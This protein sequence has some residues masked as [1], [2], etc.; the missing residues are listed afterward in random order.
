[1]NVKLIE[2]QPVTVA[3]LRYI[4]PYGESIG[5]F[6]QN[7]YYP[8]ALA[9]NLLDHP[10]YGISHDDPSSTAP[11]TAGT[12]RSAPAAGM[13]RSPSTAMANRWVRRGRRGFA[14]GC[15]RAGFSSMRAP[16]SSTTRQMPR[17]TRRPGPSS[18]S[19]AFP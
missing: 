1:M 17:A 19:F 16:A 9:N 11:D 2:R 5:R 15:P 12:R 14:I 18:A 3:Y 6:W 7:V 13:P 10:R 8:W 4:G